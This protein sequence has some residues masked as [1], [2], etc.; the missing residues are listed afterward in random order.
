V[1]CDLVLK[2]LQGADIAF[3]T[4]GQISVVAAAMLYIPSVEFPSSS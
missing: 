4:E 1:L 2:T 3:D